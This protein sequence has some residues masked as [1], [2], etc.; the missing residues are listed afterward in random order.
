MR[1]WYAK[2]LALLLAAVLA[3]SLAL[4]V[5]SIAINAEYGLYMNPMEQQLQSWKESAMSAISYEAAVDV[6]SEYLAR[7]AGE[8]GTA[9]YELY[10]N[11]F[12]GRYYRGFDWPAEAVYILRNENGTA[13]ASTGRDD[14]VGYAYTKQISV[15]RELGKVVCLGRGK[16]FPQW[17]ELK[18]NYVWTAAD[19]TPLE[20]PAEE[21]QR[22]DIVYWGEEIYRVD[23]YPQQTFTVTFSLTQAQVDAAVRSYLGG[24][25][26]LTE[27]AYAVRWY[28]IAAAA[29]SV[30]GLIGCAVWLWLVAGKKQ[31]SDEIRPRFIC[32]MPLDLLAAV[33]C[34]AGAGAF[35]LL[36]WGFYLMDSTYA[37]QEIWMGM[38]LLSIG[39]SAS[40]A[41][42]TVLAFGM[43]FFAQL[44]LGGIAWLRGTVC[45]RLLGWFWGALKGLWRRVAARF[46]G[47]GRAWGQF[48][49]RI[50]ELFRMLPVAWQ[51]ILPM[52]GW[53]VLMLLLGRARGGGALL[54]ILLGAVGVMAMV[55]G[56]WSFGRL[57]AAAQA[58]AAG[59][60]KETVSVETL[61]PSM[62]GVGEDLNKLGDVCVSAAREQ[63]RAERMRTE[64]IT[65]VS[66]DIKTP[67]TSIINYVDLLKSAE[68][69]AQRQQYLQ[70]LDRQ[71]QS[72][73]KLIEDLLELSKASSGNV[74]VDLSRTDV[75][76][77]VKQAL[78][79]FSDRLA[80]RELTVL[81]R[82]EREQLYAM[83][84]GKLLWRVLSNLL[85]N[86][87]K[88]SQSGTR[89]YVDVKQQASEVVLTL[90]NIS[91]Q[92]LNVTAAELMERFVR[93]DAS[94]S[95]QGNGLGLNIAASLME[96]QGGSLQLTVDGDLFKVE[97]RLNAE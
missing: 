14:S 23:R 94:R 15:S 9:E 77:A 2:T 51:W 42:L 17:E 16:E 39:A 28:D 56:G 66:H 46:T 31:G 37:E 50:G 81:L 38:S 1:T 76:E 92:E 75:V 71:S 57:K 4:S 7:Q 93:G 22:Y 96:V 48:F 6:A 60:L 24:D 88:Y 21:T 10:I 8:P 72:L 49:R 11:Y 34:C 35:L 70:V 89:V 32:A 82:P 20:A 18:T 40:L 13:L 91:E 61:S 83:C 52:F 44:R 3:F 79:E 64:L 78:G 53:M 41:A 69:E 29:V 19:G 47:R 73:K 87:V 97:L 30:L 27:L 5:L 85:S 67:L 45:G 43:A 59:N 86:A 90:R 95:Q 25:Y 63:V 74:A 80:E 68:D 36:R 65:N 12:G 62:R 84:D 26:R 54:Y 55:W 58:M 33:C